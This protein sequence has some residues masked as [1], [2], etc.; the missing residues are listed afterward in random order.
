[1]L[2]RVR[3]AALWGVEALA[4]EC[5]VDVGPGLP[6]FLLVGLPDATAREARERVWPA[7]RNAGFQ[8]PDRRVTVNLAPAE[9]RKE[10]ASADLAVALGMLIAT[11]QA[12]PM[13]LQCTAVIGELALDGAL[14]PVRGTLSLAEA[15]WRGGATTLL[16]PAA[17]A[18]EA[19]LVEL[20]T[21]HA[22]ATLGDAVDWLRGEELP[23]QRPA[24]PD[25]TGEQ[26]LDLTDVRGQALARRALEIAAAG[27][28]ALMLVGPPGTGKSMLARRLPGILPPLA[29]DEALVVTRLHS[30]A[31]LREPGLGLM[32]ERPFRAPHHSVTR[33]GLVGGG[34]PPRPGEISLAHH[35][36]LFLD[37]FSQY[38]K[39]TLEALREPLE[40]GDIVIRRAAGS[41]R[42][43][44]EAQLVAAMNPCPCGYLGH[45]RRGC[46]CGPTVMAGYHARVSGPILD[47]LD[48]QVE[49]PALTARELRGADASEDSATVAARVVAARERQRARGFVNFALPPARLR[50][51]A[52]LD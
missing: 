49:V 11:A 5:E 34:S 37:E 9:R 42:F 51:C 25:A 19:A 52:A 12:P 24:P 43:P 29:A 31:G 17:A 32:R 22:V 36:V 14:R 45:P 38:P 6:A 18:P 35:G 46:G 10:G 2:S 20:L 47:R 16:C 30:S 23:R 1:M 48:L 15:A 26:R 13:R 44:T 27:G 3:T 8:L 39:G 40:N 21:V 7:L 50:E 28:H 41:A 33:A 4:V